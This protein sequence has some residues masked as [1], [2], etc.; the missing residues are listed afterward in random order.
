[1]GL[2]GAKWGK[3]WAYETPKPVA[4][5]KLKQANW[6]HDGIDA[7]ILARLEREGLKPSKAADRITWLRR[8]TLDLTGLPPTLAEVD[9]FQ[10]DK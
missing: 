9:A 3:H 1:M 8:V 2:G 7:F 6:P 4:L 10:K 5:A